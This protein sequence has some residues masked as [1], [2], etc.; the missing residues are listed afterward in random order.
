MSA[1]YEATFAQAATVAFL[2]LLLGAFTLVGWAVL[3]VPLRVGF[4]MLLRVA[5]CHG[6]LPLWRSRIWGF[7]P[8]L[9]MTTSVGYLAIALILSATIGSAVVTLAIPGTSCPNVYA[10]YS[11]DFQAGLLRSAVLPVCLQ[12]ITVLQASS[13]LIELISG[14]D[15]AFASFDA[16]LEKP[17]TTP[18]RYLFDVPRQVEQRNLRIVSL[19]TLWTFCN[20]KLT[21]AENGATRRFWSS[22]TLNTIF[23]GAYPVSTVVFVFFMPYVAAVLIVFPQRG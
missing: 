2:C 22:N 4:D 1:V 9:I 19:Q 8:Y 14:G 20:K 7:L 18:Y 11:V 17:T 15:F 5:L 16:Y 13:S 21:Q 10:Y 3:L 6:K 23:A 12:W